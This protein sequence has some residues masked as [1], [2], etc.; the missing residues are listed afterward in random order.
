MTANV[1]KM[2]LL[3][4]CVKIFRLKWPLRFTLDSIEKGF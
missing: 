3:K 1:A 4:F 2:S